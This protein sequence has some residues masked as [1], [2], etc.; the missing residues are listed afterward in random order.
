VLGNAE[1]MMPF[2]IGAEDALVIGREFEA[3]FDPV[4]LISLPNYTVYLK[5]MIDRAEALAKMRPALLARNGPPER[6]IV[7]TT[8]VWVIAR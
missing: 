2:R 5:L 3:K 6:S 8:A 7:A 4:D 1:T